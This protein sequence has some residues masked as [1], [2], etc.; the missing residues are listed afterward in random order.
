MFIFIVLLN[1]DVEIGVPDTVATILSELK[2]FEYLDPPL[3][4]NK[5]IPNKIANIKAIFDLPKALNI[6]FVA[7]IILVSISEIKLCLNWRKLVKLLLQIGN[8]T[9]QLNLLK[10]T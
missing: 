3:K 7:S 6:I 9:V 4:K 5:L 2:K 8:Y 1:F 10:N